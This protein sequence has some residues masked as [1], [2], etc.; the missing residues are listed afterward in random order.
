MSQKVII[1]TIG[2]IEKKE[3]LEPVKYRN[4]VLETVTPF[5]GYHGTTIPD[6]DVPSSLL[7][8]S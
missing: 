6:T 4:L 2:T 5:P 1:E 7:I 8:S 3:S